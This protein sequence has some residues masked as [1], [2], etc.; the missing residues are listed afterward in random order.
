MNSSDLLT[1]NCMRVLSMEAI[2]KAN[3]G[4][5][6]IT[7]G[8][9]PMAYE[10]WAHHMK[11][12]PINPEWVNR[13]RFVLSAG[14][15][16]MMLYS[17]LHLFG[18]KVS[19]DDIKN[20]RQFESIT[21]GHPEHGVTPGVDAST[22]PLGQG[23]ANAVGMAMAET[24][25]ASKFNTEEYKV[26]DHYT[27]ALCGDGC[28]ME[29]IT[30]EAASLA[31]TLGLGKLI[32]LYDSNNITIEGSTDIAFTENVR[33]RFDAMNWHTVF[34][35]DGNDID[36]IGKA[37]EEAKSVTDKPSLIEIKT[38]IGYGSPNKAG[39]NASHGA[40]LGEDEVKATKAALGW[41][42][43][44][45]FVV[46]DEVKTH[47]S[48][49][50][51]E[52]TND[53]DKWDKMFDEYAEKYPEL[54]DEYKAWLNDDFLGEIENDDSFWLNTEEMATRQCSEKILNKLSEVMPNLFGGSADL[55]PS[56]K[57]IMKNS[58]FFSKG[59]REGSN[60]HFGIREIAMTAMAN[61][62]AL[63]GGIRPYIASFFVFS[64]YMKPVLRVSSITGLP[65]ACILTH[66]SIG[67]GE[68]GP[69]HQPIEQVAALRSMPNFNV[70]RPCDIN[71]TAAAWYTAMKSK[72]TPT[73]MLYSRQNTKNLEID[74][75]KALKGGYVVRESFKETPDVILMA[76]GSE[77][78]L[79]YDAY[80]VL[81]EQGIAAQVVS[82][83]C[84]ELFEEQ[85]D[86]YKESVLPH[87]VTKRIAV[88]ASSDL[89]WYRYLGID[90]K[91]INMTT[92]GKSAPYKKLF[93]YFGFTVDNVVKTT[94]DLLNK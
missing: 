94:V 6:G 71:E 84:V 81:K 16:S 45:S 9:A 68:D 65:V 12:N 17:L 93:E 83:P 88:E 18:Y 90:G 76:T 46:P 66:D 3:S 23:F 27:Y 31:G 72:H 14:H 7:M 24:H 82:M 85:S 91:L 62:M 60:I 1:I 75:R 56:N 52:L 15:G 73:A 86:E 51:K 74:G 54:A 38:T 33:Q 79:I 35:E 49:V 4:H 43:D 47:M 22:G 20:F 69:T 39:S 11:H 67:V 50:V 10:L 53:A 55:S 40:P 89:S 70:F 48:E 21:P 44:E 8:A 30:Y 34:V 77:V 59:N 63:H 36:A 32:A 28:M 37:I 13:D 26:V 25:L 61:G 41:K 5:P 80:D 29:G 78:G 57:S 42:Y 87:A 92:F 64:D 19:I 2:Q 58:D